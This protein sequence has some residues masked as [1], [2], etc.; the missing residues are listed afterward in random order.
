MVDGSSLIPPAVLV[1]FRWMVGK[2]AV[3]YS[4]CL[5]SVVVKHLI[6]AK[7]FEE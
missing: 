6:D 2:R 4:G 5:F 1:D 7:S 3:E